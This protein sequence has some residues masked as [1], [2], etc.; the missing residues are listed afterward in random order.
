VQLSSQFRSPASRLMPH[1]A[2]THLSVGG[3]LVLVT[4]GLAAGRLTLGGA[5]PAP[6]V[7][8]SAALV[9]FAVAP[10]AVTAA[11]GQVEFPYGRSVILLP[12]LLPALSAVVF[13]SSLFLP[14][15]FERLL[16]GQYPGFTVF[17]VAVGVGLAGAL[18]WWLWHLG[19]L[20]PDAPAL[21]PER[22]L[23]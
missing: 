18:V 20:V 4:I 22:W 8:L 17:L 7:A 13:F 6:A 23:F 5:M 10:G 14:E 1:F 16:A 2:A 3:G 9:V 15:P 19:E 11:A 21:S 12:T